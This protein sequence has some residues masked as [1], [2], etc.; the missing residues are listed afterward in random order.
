MTL[1]SSI[2]KELSMVKIRQKIVEDFLSERKL[3]LN[4][5]KQKM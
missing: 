2:Y 5:I 1:R 3:K 4:S